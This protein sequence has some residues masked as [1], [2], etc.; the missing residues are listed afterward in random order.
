MF[1][2]INLLDYVNKT[3]NPSRLQ[4]NI[5]TLLKEMNQTEYGIYIIQTQTNL[6]LEETKKVV[7]FIWV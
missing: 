5:D 1:R 7:E 3:D 4:E 6:S 2:Y